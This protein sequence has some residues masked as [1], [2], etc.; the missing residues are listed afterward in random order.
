MSNEEKQLLLN[1]LCA[2]LPYGAICYNSDTESDF[3]LYDVAGTDSDYPTFNYGYGNLETVKPYLRPMSSMTEEERLI[4]RNI[5]VIDADDVVSHI[6][7]LNENMFDYRNL[8]LMGLALE[9]PDGMY[10]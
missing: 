4:C 5:D 10:K 6:D 7:W 8:I 1:D 9:A 3:K 2:R